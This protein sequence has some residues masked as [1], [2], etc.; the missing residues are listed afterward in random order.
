[1]PVGCLAAHVEIRFTPEDF[2]ERLPDEAII[3]DD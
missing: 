1:V 2:G 3:V